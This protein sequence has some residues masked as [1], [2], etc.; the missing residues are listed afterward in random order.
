MKDPSRLLL[1]QTGTLEARLLEAVRDIDPPAAAHGEVWRRMAVATGTGAATLAV[2]TPLAARAVAGAGT[3]ALAQA[4]WLSV[5]KWIAVV[6]TL[7][8]A[9]GIGVHWVV[10]ARTAAPNV[11]GST[12]SPSVRPAA[13]AQSLIPSMQAAPESVPLTAPEQAP[14]SGNGVATGR[15]PAA[16][17]LDVESTLL[18]RAREKL[19]S[20][21][22]KGSLDDIAILAV[23]FPRGELAQEREVVAIKALLSQGQRAAAA[24]RTADFL[25]MHPSSPYAESLRQALRP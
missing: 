18:R 25:R 21:D 7:A 2:A 12:M 23:R 22:P 1:S 9:A 19:E 14:S 8:P 20:G 15:S 10:S 4:G 16:S 11:A 13:R 17:R 6:G 24:A 5:I 3:K